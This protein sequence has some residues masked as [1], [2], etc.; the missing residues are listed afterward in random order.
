MRGVLAHPAFG[1]AFYPAAN[2]KNAGV[3]ATVQISKT[4]AIALSSVALLAGG[5]RSMAN[6]NDMPGDSE[7]LE[8]A[9]AA[10]E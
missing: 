1:R 5:P 2:H 10:A 3:I 8:T 4:F 7:W 6:A 9:R